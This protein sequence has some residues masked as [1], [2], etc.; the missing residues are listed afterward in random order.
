MYTVNFFNI[1]GIR[2]LI[3]ILFF[4]PLQLDFHK[5]VLKPD[6]EKDHV[7][8][9]DVPQNRLPPLMPEQDRHKGRER[10]RVVDRERDRERDRGVVGV[11]DLWAEREREMERRERARGEREWDRDK[12]REFARPGEEERRSRSRDRERRRRERAKSKERKTDKKGK[13]G[14]I[15]SGNREEKKDQKPCFSITW[16][17]VRT[18]ILVQ[19]SCP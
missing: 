8:Q 10:D 6:K 19:K 9:P 13:M 17:M 1:S 12:V 18:I 3:S 11:R 16:K 5:G 14:E 2:Q 7:P 15:R 4:F